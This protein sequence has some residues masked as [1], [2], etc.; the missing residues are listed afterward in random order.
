MGRLQAGGVSDVG[1]GPKQGKSLRRGG[2]LVL[3]W[4]QCCPHKVP[5]L[6]P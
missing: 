5:H 6:P 3:S 1:W 4:P 2:L